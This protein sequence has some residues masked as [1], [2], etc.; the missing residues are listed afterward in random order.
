MVHSARLE[1]ECASARVG[2]N[3]TSSAF[4]SPKLAER[5]RASLSYGETKSAPLDWKDIWIK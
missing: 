5:R 1:S 3:P 2:S 4:A